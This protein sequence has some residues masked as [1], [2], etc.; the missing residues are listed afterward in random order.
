MKIFNLM[1]TLTMMATSVH[2]SAS[3]IGSDQQGD[4]NSYLIAV[5]NDGDEAET[6]FN[7]LKVQAQ[8]VNGEQVKT[9]STSSGFAKIICVAKDG[10][11]FG[12]NYECLIQYS[13]IQQDQASRLKLHRYFIPGEGSGIR[14]IDVQ[15]LSV[16][17]SA[18][19]AQE[20]C[21]SMELNPKTGE[22]RSHTGQRLFKL[23]FA[24]FGDAASINGGE[25]Y[26]TLEYKVE[27][28]KNSSALL[29]SMAIGHAILATG[30][31]V[32]YY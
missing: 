13:A 30:I 8:E 14:K 15:E 6:I 26:T 32:I 27:K 28:Q 22:F 31:G 1:L 11:F 23:A 4:K 21:S 25:M 17:L 5:N 12:K 3:N 16:S 10:T 18:Q 9:L 2:A 29:W 24:C 7:H 19:D 20:I